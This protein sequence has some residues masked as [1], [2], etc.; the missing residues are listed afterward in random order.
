LW[1]LAADG[2]VWCASWFAG[3][4]IWWCSID[5]PVARPNAAL[6]RVM[7]LL[8]R[9]SGRRES[10]A[11]LSGPL[12]IRAICP[13]AKLPNRGVRESPNDTAD[14]HAAPEGNRSFCCEYSRVDACGNGIGLSACAGSE[15]ALGESRLRGSQA[16][17]NSNCQKN[18]R[19]HFSSSTTPHIACNVVVNAFQQY[20]R[21]A[22]LATAKL[23]R[24]RPILG[25]AHPPLRETA[26]IH[27]RFTIGTC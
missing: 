9:E 19:K 6:R 22:R 1:W 17:L 23:E 14:C 18:R 25:L 27:W 8:L 15:V 3:A 4:P 12:G 26:R 24:R 20:E 21:L 11:L 13:G 5:C 10:K 16:S 2:P 7:S